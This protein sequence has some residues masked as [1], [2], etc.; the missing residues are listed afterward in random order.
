MGGEVWLTKI[1]YKRRVLDPKHRIMYRHSCISHYGCTCW[2]G[3][4]WTE[5]CRESSLSGEIWSKPRDLVPAIVALVLV[6]MVHQERGQSLIR[7][8]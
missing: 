7:Q 6:I 8:C 4:D 1:S 2:K 3:R 5:L